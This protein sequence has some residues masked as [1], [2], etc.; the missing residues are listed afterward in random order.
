LSANQGLQID[1]DYAWGYFD[2]ARFKCKA[3][4]FDEA[5]QAIDAALEKRPGLRAHMEKDGEF[6]RLCVRYSNSVWKVPTPCSASLE[7]VA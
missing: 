5:R 2:L 4:A 6:Q 7:G 3:G 1:P